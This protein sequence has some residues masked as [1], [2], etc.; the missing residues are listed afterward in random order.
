MLKKI[1]FIERE[2]NDIRKRINH[3]EEQE[4]E[5]FWR[6]I[7]RATLIDIKDKANNIIKEWLNIEVKLNNFGK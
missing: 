2:S 1:R 6:Y 7:E 4:Q 3:C 5:Q